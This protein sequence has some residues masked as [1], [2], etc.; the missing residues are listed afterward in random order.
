M[1]FLTLAT[2]STAVGAPLAGGK[3]AA[4]SRVTPVARNTLGPVTGIPSLGAPQPR[5]LNA[6]VGQ[7]GLQQGFALGLGLA[8]AHNLFTRQFNPLSGPGGRCQELVNAGFFSNASA[9]QSHFGP[10]RR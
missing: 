7:P 6:V 3:E 1:S 2:A 10:R 8:P 5:T 9:C 4:E